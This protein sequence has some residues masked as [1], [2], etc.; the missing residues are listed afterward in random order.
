MTLHLLI[1]S[2]RIVAVVISLTIF[3]NLLSGFHSSTALAFKPSPLFKKTPN[4]I[5]HEEI[6]EEAI[7]E[8]IESEG[9]IPGVTSV[10]GSV[11]SAI[12]E[13]KERDRDVDRQQRQLQGHRRR[14]EDRHDGRGKPRLHTQHVGLPV[15]EDG[16][17]AQLREVLGHQP[18]DRLIAVEREEL[19]PRNARSGGR[20]SG[21]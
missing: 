1:F 12:D 6:T 5:T 11:Q 17:R 4:D 13:I 16:K 20:P 21:G 15:P 18:G 19:G 2:R 14:A 10:T 3:L 9:I 8:L 7:R